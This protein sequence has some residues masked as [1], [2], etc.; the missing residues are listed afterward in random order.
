MSNLT[1]TIEV[2][3]NE[4]PNQRTTNRSNQSNQSW[5]RLVQFE[6]RQMREESDNVKEQLKIRLQCRKRH[7]DPAHSIFQTIYRLI[8]SLAL[9]SLASG[10]SR[11]RTVNAISNSATSIHFKM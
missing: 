6:D 1:I 7:Q 5:N 11:A 10:I 4:V 9:Y 3:Q 2:N 8:K